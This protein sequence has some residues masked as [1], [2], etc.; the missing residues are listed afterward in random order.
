M[1]WAGF[2][3]LATSTAP[4]VGVRGGS[5]VC[6]GRW[7]SSSLCPPP[8]PVR[9]TSSILLGN[10]RCIDLPRALKTTGALLS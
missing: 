2:G 3:A 5:C 7:T 9:A 8:L 10:G 4:S 1:K 6:G